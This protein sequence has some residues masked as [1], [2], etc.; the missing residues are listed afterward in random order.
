[1]FDQIRSGIAGN[2]LDLISIIYFI[3]MNCDKNCVSPSS[4]FKEDR[5]YE[6]EC[7]IKT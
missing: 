5:E 3:E 6:N 2:M 4:A 1:M 7:M